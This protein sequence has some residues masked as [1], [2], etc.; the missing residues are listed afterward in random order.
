MKLPKFK[1][2]MIVPLFIAVIFISSIFV[3]FSSGGLQ[4]HKARLI[5]DFGQP[6]LLFDREVALGANTT[7]IQLLSNYAQSIELKD[8]QIYCII[9]YCNTNLTKWYFSTVNEM[10]MEADPGISPDSYIVK[11]KDVILFRYEVIRNQT[12]N[13]TA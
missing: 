1:L 4:A 7:A 8:T 3:V 11:D 10:G 12:T 13:T 5:V 6:G 2:K 9:D